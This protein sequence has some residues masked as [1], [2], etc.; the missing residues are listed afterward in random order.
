MLETATRKIL[1]VE[2]EADTARIIQLG[3]EQGGYEVITVHN[4]TEA[5]AVVATA[6]PDLILLDVEMPGMNGLQVL[7]HLKR[8]AATRHIPVVML[9]AAAD[10]PDMQ[11]GW[12]HGTDLYLT[13]PINPIDLATYMR[14]LLS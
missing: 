2:D 12:E 5:L 8:D 6:Q 7:D 9:T 3:L 11:R 14:T 10:Y 1:V 13:K 4:G